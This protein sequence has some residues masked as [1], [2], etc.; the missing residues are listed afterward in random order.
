MSACLSERDCNRPTEHTEEDQWEGCRRAESTITDGCNRG[1]NGSTLTRPT[2]P[3]SGPPAAPTA[4]AARPHRTPP[5]APASPALRQSK[6]PTLPP[7]RGRWRPG[8]RS[9]RPGV[10][11]GRGHEVACA[12]TWCGTLHGWNPCTQQA[13]RTS[14]RMPMGPHPAS[15][16]FVFTVPAGGGCQTG[17]LWVPQPIGRAQQQGTPAWPGGGAPWP[18]ALAPAGPPA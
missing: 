18:P 15:S 17:A 7:G 3:P 8:A 12:A 4:A 11:G 2:L 16:I 6:R 10:G 1:W 14:T 9:L 5:P 13:G